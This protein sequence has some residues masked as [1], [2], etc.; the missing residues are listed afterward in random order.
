MPEYRQK[1]SPS[2]AFLSAVNCVNPESAFRHQG[3]SGTAD[4]RLVQH[5]PALLAQ[6]G[7]CI[8]CRSYL[9]KNR[10]SLRRLRID[11]L[12]AQLC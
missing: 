9:M 10:L 1:V 7:L 6:H 2:S 3:Q 12:S 8:R 5:C 4:R 11:T